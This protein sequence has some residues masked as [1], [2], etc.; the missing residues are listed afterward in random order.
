MLIKRLTPVTFIAIS[1][2]GLMASLQ[3]INPILALYVYR[4]LNATE[5]DVGLVFASFSIAS[6]ALRIPVIL[7]IASI[8]LSNI[9]LVGLT[10][11]ALSILAYTFVEDVGMMIPLR[12]IHGLSVALDNTAMLTLAGLSAPREEKTTYSVAGYA[13]AVAFGL[14]MGPAIATLSVSILGLSP[15]LFI[16]FLVSLLPIISSYLFIRGTRGI[17]LGHV[18][19]GVSWRDFLIAL[20]RAGLRVSST[21]F[22]AF[23][24]TYGIFIAYAPLLAGIRYGIPDNLITFL[25]LGYYTI[26]FSIRATLPKLLSRTTIQSLIIKSLIIATAALLT[27]GIAQ[28]AIIFMLGFEML[29]IA[30]S[31]IFPLTA[32]IAVR[33]IPP[34]MRILGNA[35]YLAAWDAGALLGPLTAAFLS[36]ILDIQA[37][38]LVAVSIPL[39]SILVARTI[40]RVGID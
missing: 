2:F 22:F 8:P 34:N 5:S 25:F 7:L 32:I 30:H 19:S 24:F 23:A 29:G 10:I 33:A 6:L 21:I 15:T 36:L 31:L 35:I 13:A 39:L 9:L 12:A 38:L 37:I 16:A 18:T 3:V 11:N 20:H 28:N 14:M 40:H 26:T 27:M 17:W 4:E 1:G